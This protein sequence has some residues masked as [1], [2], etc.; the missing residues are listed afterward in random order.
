MARNRIKPD[1]RLSLILSSALALQVLTFPD[2]FLLDL[3][4]NSRSTLLTVAQSVSMVGWIVLIFATP[5]LI[6]VRLSMWRRFSIY[7][8]VT[9]SI[10]PAGLLLVRIAH[11]MFTGDSAV[12]RYVNFPIFLF[13][14]FVVPALYWGMAWRAAGLTRRALGRN[15]MARNRP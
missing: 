1:L 13:S 11:S 5:L 9:A 2:L 15:Q 10:W 12:D 3:S 4:S 6:A 7:L 14:D 8:T